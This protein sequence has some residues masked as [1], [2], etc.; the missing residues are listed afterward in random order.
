SAL[1]DAGSVQKLRLVVWV[2]TARAAHH[3]TVAIR[4]S[5]QPF[6]DSA[7]ANIPAW[8]TVRNGQ[9]E[10][11]P[12]GR[13]FQYRLMVNASA[14]TTVIRE[15]FLDTTP[16]SIRRAKPR[17]ALD[18]LVTSMMYQTTLEKLHALYSS[19]PS[20]PS[21]PLPPLP[22]SVFNAAERGAYILRNHAGQP[23]REDT[24]RYQPQ[25]EETY[26]AARFGTRLVMRIH[27]GA[28]FSPLTLRPSD[29]VMRAKDGRQKTGPFAQHRAINFFDG[30]F[31]AEYLTGIRGAVRHYRQHNPGVIGY[32]IAPPEFFYDTEPW[33]DM[34][35]LGG[36]G[37]LARDRYV[38]FMAG[39]GITVDDWPAMSD[40]DVSLDRDYYLWVYW[41]H[42]EAHHYLA[43]IAR[44]IREEDPRA[45]IGALN[46]V[47]DSGLRGVEP[48]FIEANP[49]FS[50]YYSSNMFPR[51]PGPDGLTGGAILS[52]TRPNVLGHSRKLNLAEFD[53]W[54]P[55][56]DL[57]RMETWVRYSQM[58][59]I[60]PVP[61]VFGD[62]L[63]GSPPSNHLTKYHGMTGE[64]LTLPIIEA[65]GNVVRETHSLRHGKKFS[66]VAVVLPGFSLYAMLE[67]GAW[68]PVRNFPLQTRLLATLLEHGA[69][70]DLIS[71][72][73]IDRALLDNYKLVVWQQPVATPWIVKALRETRAS[74]LALG[75]AGTLQVPGPHALQVA[76]DPEQ[77]TTALLHAWPSRDANRTPPAATTCL[78][79]GG[80]IHEIATSI[81]FGNTAHPLLRG[82]N[83]KRF[84]VSGKGIGG[85]G[86]SLPYVSQLQGTSLATDDSGQTVFAIK[87]D[88]SRHVIHFGV[89]PDFV[90]GQGN[91]AS[92]FPADTLAT[93]WENI[94]DFIRIEYFPDMGPLRIMRTSAHLLIENTADSE[95]RGPVPRPRNAAS[96]W[97]ESLRDTNIVIPACG[98]VLL[99]FVTA[100][101]PC[102]SP[103]DRA[104]AACGRE[105]SSI[106]GAPRGR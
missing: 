78:P 15:V 28:T 53:L 63:K 13:F 27:P 5:E 18:S 54:S 29:V 1:L 45:E 34:T 69:G 20:R 7:P 85:G 26:L 68:K 88:A 33:P 24:W 81:T 46:Y 89:P 51:V 38:R 57:K 96:P 59:H 40:G 86:H 49:D 94:W 30:Q 16:P 83:G 17:P 104:G 9:T 71:E 44:V 31:M 91:D 102:A 14:P 11:L 90:D 19:R 41:R 50:F 21:P 12:A 97:A 79:T 93:F 42:Q 106:P 22:S 76:H 66:Q 48:G 36:F 82:L 43:R 80:R 62:F 98:S 87:K 65:Q 52:F 103:R 92:L 70:F 74:V 35:W 67:K 32:N 37:D 72:G 10:G 25:V 39:L 47:A 6:G 73:Q 4:A 105:N 60:L 100:A 55:Y 3:I 75:W 77:F 95:Y 101:R 99:P 61:I 64:P 84:R 58:E 56:V 23:I 8:T 2:V